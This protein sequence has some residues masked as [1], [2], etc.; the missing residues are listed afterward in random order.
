MSV[1]YAL[2]IK[3]VGFGATNSSGLIILLPVRW[4]RRFDPSGKSFSGIKLELFRKAVTLRL[5]PR[6]QR[7]VESLCSHL[8]LSKQGAN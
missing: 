2:V 1:L 8:L 3:N 6:R 5:V 4:K 7:K